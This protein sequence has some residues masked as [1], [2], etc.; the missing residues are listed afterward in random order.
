MNVGDHVVWKGPGLARIVRI[1]NEGAD[2][3]LFRT[4]YGTVLDRGCTA[5]SGPGNGTY[6]V[7]VV[8]EGSQAIY[9]QVEFR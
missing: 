3:L 6:P 9:V 2:E 1:E 7:S 5:D 4:R 8:M